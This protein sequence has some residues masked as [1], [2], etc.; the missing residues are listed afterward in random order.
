[1]WYE[2]VEERDPKGREPPRLRAKEISYYCH[3][4]DVEGLRPLVWA[5]GYQRQ[6]DR[7]GEVVFIADG[8]AWIWRL[9]SY[10]F[11]HAVQIVDYCHAAAYLTPIAQAVWGETEE[12]QAWLE[13]TRAI[14]KQGRI[15]EVIGIC[16]GYGRH[17]QAQE[18]VHKAVTYYRNNAE[19]MD[20]GRL[21]AAG[22][23]I[24]SGSVESACK[25]IGTQRLKRA[26]ARWGHEGAQD[27]AKARA[28]WLS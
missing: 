17:A 13:A 23:L 21:Q 22:Y 10:H 14:L 8:A 4:G 11:P 5:T 28:A 3:L 12:G 25:R 2:A 20:Y 16:E 27:T 6:V 1:C 19:R 9:V 15:E 7:A 24:G 26:G 18:A